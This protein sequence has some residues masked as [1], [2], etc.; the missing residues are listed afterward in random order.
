MEQFINAPAN[1]FSEMLAGL[2]GDC[3][4]F[5]DQAYPT[6]FNPSHGDIGF[7]RNPANDKIRLLIQNSVQYSGQTPSLQRWSGD[8]VLE[9]NDAAALIQWLHD[10][11]A[12]AMAFTATVVGQGQA[13]VSRP[14]PEITDTRQVTARIDNESDALYID[15]DRIFA[16]LVGSVKGQDDAMKALSAALSRHIARR[17]PRRPLTLFAVGPT[18]VGKT[19]TGLCVT[20]VLNQLSENGAN[21]EFLRLDMCEYREAH[22]V[23]QLL[24]SPQGYVGYGEG[25]QLTDALSRNP[26]TVVLF[27]EI[28]KAH[29]DILKVLMNAMDAGRLSSPSRGNGTSHEVDCRK[30]IFFFSSNLETESIHRSLEQRAAYAAPETV[31]EICRTHLKV[32]GIPPELIGRIGH[33]LAFRPLSA[34][35]KAEIV[36]IEIRDAA[37]EYGLDLGKVDPDVVVDVIQS[38]KAHCFGAR[39]YDYQIHRLLGRAFAQAGRQRVT[40]PIRIKGPAP[41]E[42]ETLAGIQSTQPPNETGQAVGCQ[43]VE[44]DSRMCKGPDTPS[45]ST[46][47]LT[48]TSNRD[49]EP[50]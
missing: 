35:S 21:Y 8:G 6:G 34:K 39:A 49:D 25:A 20:T 4:R 15:E 9:F 14:A 40:G 48:A 27:D 1:A 17:E 37:R 43:T 28:E 7:E 38:S 13:S 36:A 19:K 23:S 29:P 26:R 18:G 31:D 41:Y 33:F 47:P 12:P 2:N 10:D 16:A 11:V 30:S 22:R 50:R 32:A 24:G 42:F 46:E 3:I 5:S 45:G 44:G